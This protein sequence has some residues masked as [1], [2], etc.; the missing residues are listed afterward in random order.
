MGIR[1]LLLRGVDS[2][3]RGFL[4]RS[5]VVASIRIVGLLFV[6]LLQLLL[7]RLVGDSLEYGKYAWGQSLLFLVG[8]LAAMGIPVATSRFIASLSA[9]QNDRAAT[10]VIDRARLL[11]TMSSALLLMLALG[12]VLLGSKIPNHNFYWELSVIALLLAPGVSLALLYQH[13]SIAR[14]WIILAFLPMQVLRPVI[15]AVLSVLVWWLSGRNLTGDLTLLLAGISIFLVYVPQAVIFKS[16]QAKLPSANKKVGINAD[17][18]PGNLFRTS[19][20]I[21]ITRTASVTMEYSNVLLVGFLAGPAAAGAYFAAERLALLASVPSS[22]VSSVSQPEMAAASA[23]NERGLLRTLTVRAAHGSLWPTTGIALVLIIFSSPL[24]SLFGDAF[25]HAA[26]VLVV[27]AI[28]EIV[29]VVTGPAKDLLL[30]TGHQRLL[31]RVMISTSVIH[32]LLLIV[33][34]PNGGAV[35]AALTSAISGLF[36]SLWLMLLVRREI[37]INP[38]I[39]AGRI[40]DES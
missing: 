7:A 19:F 30:M 1:R 39:F 35:G 28:G 11:L 23:R 10:A 2:H 36:S 18:H 12:M 31:P 34:V 8:S 37:A 22:I 14:H 6:F 26:P 24:L 16:R 32:L 38:T 27:L 13:M 21:F 15:I 3:L 25:S 40:I 5:A 9:H 4:K 20:P 29:T 33:L 17:F